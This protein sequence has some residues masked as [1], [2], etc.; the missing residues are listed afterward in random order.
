MLT[1]PVTLTFGAS[2]VRYEF[3][4]VG[5]A[6]WRARKLDGVADPYLV[7]TARRTCTCDAGRCRRR[8]KHLTKCL[9][10]EKE[11]MAKA[12]SAPPAEPAGV[13]ATIP[14]PAP[15]VE[16]AAPGPVGEELGDDE[17]A[18]N[19]RVLDQQERN[20]VYVVTVQAIGRNA[21]DQDVGAVALSKSAEGRA[22]D[23]MR[24]VTLAKKRARASILGR[25]E[26]TEEV[27]LIPADPPAPAATV[28]LC[29]PLPPTPPAPESTPTP[30]PAFGPSAEATLRA[31]VLTQIGQ[32]TAAL[33]IKPTQV[34][35]KLREFYGVATFGE[36]TP[37][38]LVDF[39][40][41]LIQLRDKV[42]TAK[43]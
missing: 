20:G 32:L 26:P 12:K 33:N 36:M 30:A 9:E 28:P 39:H 14:P 5:P 8:C 34:D 21:L 6:S 2:D 4:R 31:E 25:P 7:N 22:A 15:A 35:A 23:I 38:Q 40:K 37:D 3:A 17:P 11:V 29:A 42:G 27:P 1:V 41:R 18:F 13:T 24:A 10:L 16:T 19:F 43:K